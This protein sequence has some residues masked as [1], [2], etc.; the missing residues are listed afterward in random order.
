[1][2]TWNDVVKTAPEFAA[3]AQEKFDAYKHKTIAT[4]R[5]DGSPRISGIE[6]EFVAGEVVLGM[7]PESNKAKDVR[8]DGRVALHSGS[9]DPKEGTFSGDAKLSGLCVEITDRDE[10]V[11]IFKAMGAPEEVHESPVFRIDLREVVVTRV[12]ESGDHLE[13]LLWK[14]GEVKNLRA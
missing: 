6:A 2:A 13:I 4:L 3:L 5:A 10:A 12:A 11:R 14:D 8:R 9:P 7:M 1:M